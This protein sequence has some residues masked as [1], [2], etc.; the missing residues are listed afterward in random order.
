[1]PLPRSREMGWALAAIAAFVIGSL[2][3]KT[4]ATFAAPYYTIIDRY[5]AAGHPWKTGTVEVKPNDRGPGFVLT[6]TNEVRRQYSDAQ[7]AARTVARVQVGEAI[8]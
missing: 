1:M 2:C 4:Y 7:A 3:A 5:F 6:S 8:E